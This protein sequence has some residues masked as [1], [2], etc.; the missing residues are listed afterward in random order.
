MQKIALKIAE[1][2][3]LNIETTKIN[4][5]NITVSI[6]ITVNNESKNEFDTLFKEADSALYT[7]KKN[8]RNRIVLF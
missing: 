8:G 6:G 4:D 7:A 5:I 1:I 2:I 3:R